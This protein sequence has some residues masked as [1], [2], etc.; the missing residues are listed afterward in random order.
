MLNKKE[1][2]NKTENESTDLKRENIYEEISVDEL[3]RMQ[4]NNQE[5]RHAVITAE[6]STEADI[7]TKDSPPASILAVYAKV[8]FA[9]KRRD[10]IEKSKSV[11]SQK[12]TSLHM[13]PIFKAE[14]CFIEPSTEQP[15]FLQDD[16]LYAGHPVVRETPSP[17]S[18][19]ASANSVD[20]K[21]YGFWDI[22]KRCKFK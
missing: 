18:S 9:Q 3:N 2:L 22:Y 7:Q 11:P 15:Y 13:V 19:G 12:K 14:K 6:L 1:A 10:R 20:T 5:V 4:A 21:V 8:D 16:M 17:S